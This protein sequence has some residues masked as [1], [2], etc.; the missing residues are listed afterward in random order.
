MTFHQ[1]KSVN[2]IAINRVWGFGM[3]A[4]GAEAGGRAARRPFP[5]L[6]N[7]AVALRVLR[8]R[9]RHVARIMYDWWQLRRAVV[10]LQNMPD[11][12]L[13]DIGVTR[14]EIGHVVR[15]GRDSLF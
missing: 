14:E 6:R 8:L 13:R 4:S 5:P 11:R 10:E 7:L 15:F 2:I 9:T 1:E 12:M 3:R